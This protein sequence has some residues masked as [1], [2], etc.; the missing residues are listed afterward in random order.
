[1]TFL[2]ALTTSTITKALRL[3][4]CNIGRYARASSGSRAII[5]SNVI[6]SSSSA[7]ATASKGRLESKNISTQLLHLSGSNPTYAK[8]RHDDDDIGRPLRRKFSSSSSVST[9]GDDVDS[10]LDSILDDVLSA[11]DP[12]TAGDVA[13]DSILNDVMSDVE[14]GTTNLNSNYKHHSIP[15]ILVEV[16]IRTQVLIYFLY[17]NR[18]RHKR[19]HK[20]KPHG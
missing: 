13:F 14:H 17:S 11:D 3:S 2:L 8:A 16:C 10:V 9:G 12:K 18:N 1:M 7:S 5:G 20:S 19:T 4:R 6:L 15:D